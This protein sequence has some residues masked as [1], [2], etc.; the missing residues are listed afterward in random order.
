MVLH[1]VQ[2][3]DQPGID[4][5]CRK[6]DG[7]VVTTVVSHDGRIHLPA[8]LRKRLKLSLGDELEIVVEDDEAFTLR[9]IRRQPN[10]GLVNLLLACPYPFEIPSR[11]C[12]ESSALLL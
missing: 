10:Q 6:Q 7:F 8:S 9:R 4:R 2:L 1:P 11:K 3:S 12:D 5:T